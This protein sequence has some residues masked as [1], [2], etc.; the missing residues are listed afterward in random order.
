[1]GWMRRRGDRVVITSGQYAGRY[2]TIEINVFQ[3]TVDY[4]NE[5]AN[6]PR[7]A[8]HG[9]TGDGEVEEASRVVEGDVLPNYS[10]DIRSVAR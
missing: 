10:T 1:M 5:F 6:T 3:R 9:G 4:P 8:G 2:G 7:H